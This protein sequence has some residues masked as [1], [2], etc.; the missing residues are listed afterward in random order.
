MRFA[1][2]RV[3]DYI[4][5]IA[6]VDIAP[7]VFGDEV[8]PKI[9]EGPIGRAGNL[10]V[11]VDD[12]TPLFGAGREGKVVGSRRPDQQ[13]GAEGPSAR[14]RTLRTACLGHFPGFRP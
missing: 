10:E 4:F 11:A 14:K 3:A 7:I 5:P 6:G 9:G 12:G 2:G 1:H 13:R 8:G